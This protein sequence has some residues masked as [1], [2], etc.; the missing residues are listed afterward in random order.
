M[1]V[2]YFIHLLVFLL[3]SS[4]PPVHLSTPAYIPHLPNPQ[5]HLPT[6]T[7]PYPY[8]FKPPPP[9]PGLKR[10][11]INR[12]ELPLVAWEQFFRRYSIVFHCLDYSSRRILL[13]YNSKKLNCIRSCCFYDSKRSFRGSSSINKLFFKTGCKSRFHTWKLCV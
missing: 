2:K 3:L 6:P 9:P 13:F 8:H 1:I 12:L 5:H 11:A 10:A 4:L 7:K